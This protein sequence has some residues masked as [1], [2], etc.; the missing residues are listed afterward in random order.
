MR[1]LD[2][3][4]D[5]TAVSRFLPWIM[6]GLLY[7]AVIALAAAAIA[8]G[9]LQLFDQRDQM[10]T[11]S[12]P[13]A[14][15]SE[16]GDRDVANIL[17]VLEEAREVASAT[18]VGDDELQDLIEPWLGERREGEDLPL[19]RLIDVTLDPIGQP[20]LRTL[21]QR[22]R[23]VVPDATIGIQEVSEDRGQ[24][25]AAF[26]RIVGIAIGIL[27]LLCSLA[28]VTV[29]TSLSLAMHNDTVKLLRYMGAQDGY[30]AR[31]FERFAL[32]SGLRGGIIGFF[33]AMLTVLAVLYSM[34]NL[35][36]TN[37]VRLGLRPVDWVFL[38]CVP[39]VAALLCT[40]TARLTALWNLGR[41]T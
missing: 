20:D 14:G 39:V 38:A 19:P 34:Q 18:V 7:L 28:I 36:I 37:T 33:L 40:L 8:D 17:R 16:D 1:N 32:Q 11:V 4:L 30:L 24:R 3:P 29:V 15:I 10:V 25:Q 21:E 23:E 2:L 6:A 31:Q 22:L 12:L 27:L 5:Q 26:F 9:A 41:L 35:E 13:T